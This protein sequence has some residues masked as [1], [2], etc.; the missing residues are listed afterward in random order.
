M[1]DQGGMMNYRYLTHSVGGFIQQVAVCYVQRGYWF[2]VAGQIPAQKDPHKVDR[3]LLDKYDI[4]LS[5][6]QRC[7]RKKEGQASV[8]YIRYQDTFLLLATQGAHPFFVKE[9]SIRDA[10][11][12]P[13]PL[14]GYS[15]SYR[16]GR[17]LVSLDKE[18][19]RNLEAYFLHLALHRKADSLEQE[20]RK[21]PFDPYR[22]VYKQVLSVWKAVNERR[23]T[24]GFDLVPYSAIKT[25]RRIYRPFES[26][27]AGKKA[28]IEEVVDLERDAVG[29]HSV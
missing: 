13:I 24:A 21:L 11:R 29:G 18:T 27:N 8:Q 5:K 26:E 20:F 19:Y 14:F 12:F 3:H 17:A 28:Q 2:Y 1:I 16:N 15:I 9:A 22:P 6:F 4:D 23:K 10:R 25:K 7:R